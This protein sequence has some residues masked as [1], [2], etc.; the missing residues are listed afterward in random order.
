MTTWQPG[1]PGA[2]EAA[3]ALAGRF[4]PAGA[5]AGRGRRRGGNLAG[6]REGDRGRRL[7]RRG[8]DHAVARALFARSRAM[9]GAHGPG[10]VGRLAS[11]ESRGARRLPEDGMSRGGG[12]CAR[13]R[14]APRLAH[15]GRAMTRACWRPWATTSRRSPPTRAGGRARRRRRIDFGDAAPPNTW[16]WPPRTSCSSS[17]R[18]CWCSAGS[19]PTRR[20]CCS[21]RC[22][23]RS[24]GDCRGAD[25]R[26]AR[27]RDR[28]A[29][30]G[31]RR[32]WRGTTGHLA[33]R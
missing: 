10:H 8:R 18:R 30:R 26:R 13:H 3:A 33:P 5:A 4:R 14:P 27:D 32:D 2:G 9:T 19:W 23:P 12:R 1:S 21:S 28:H 20:T 25:D 24:D 11:P 6:C 16:A 17:I 7:L 15:Q 31:R 22:G 29:R